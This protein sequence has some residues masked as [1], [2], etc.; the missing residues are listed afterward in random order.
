MLYIF[1]VSTANLVWATESYDNLDLK[2]LN[3]LTKKNLRAGNYELAF[4]QAKETL[5]RAR[6]QNDPIVLSDAL[7]NIASTQLYLGLFENALIYYEKS[8]KTAQQSSYIVGVERAINNISGLYIQTK[9]LEKAYEILLELPVFNGVDRP[10][11]R[12][13]MSYISLAR[14]LHDLERNE[15]AK[16]YLKK[17]ESLFVDNDLDFYKTYWF[18]LD[19]DIKRSD[20]KHEEALQSF[21]SALDIATKRGFNGVEV[22]AIESIAYVHMHKGESDKA[23]RLIDEG[24]AKANEINLNQKKISLL[25]LIYKIE[26][27]EGNYQKAL[28]TLEEINVL[29][30][31]ISGTKVQILLAIAESERQMEK[32]KQQLLESQQKERLATLELEKNYQRQIVFGLLTLISV[33]GILFWNYL[34]NAKKEIERQKHLNKELQSVDRLKDRIL[35]NT[36]HELRTP[37]NGIIGL[38][39]AILVEYGDDFD[40]ELIKS[41][42]MI[43]Q[44]G[45]QLSSIVNDILDFAQI[46]TQHLHIRPENFDL[47][48]LI[49]EVK[50]LCHSMTSNTEIDL[51]CNL[52]MME[53]TVYQDQQRVRQILYNLIGNA[54]KFTPKGHVEISCQLKDKVVV[55]SVKDTGIGIPKEKLETVFRG[56]EQIDP[57]DTRNYSGSGLGLAISRELAKFMGGGISIASE[58]NKGT[59]VIFTVPV[60]YQNAVDQ[61]EA[62]EARAS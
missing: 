29:A 44:A 7:S 59:E 61:N 62:E 46:K 3:Q 8:L 21:N 47:I 27:K 33:A 36:S 4:L 56:F 43:N 2:S 14:T 5:K 35:T 12:Q 55:I 39:N 16:E 38:S 22:M 30:E 52:E 10:I 11:D 60:N 51:R 48:R 26:K 17:A 58:L 19:G 24:I 37:L 40:Q 18:L 20:K 54:I 25:E 50:N 32:T 49:L 13:I 53:M 9:N 1:T 42:E 45:S 31:T 57:S 15:E 41:L 23:R 28:N 6:E 34:R